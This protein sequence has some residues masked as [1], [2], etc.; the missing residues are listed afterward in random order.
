VPSTP[1]GSTRPSPTGPLP[2]WPIVLRALRQARGITQAGWGARLGYSDKTVRRWERGE[3]APDAAAEAALL[4]VLQEEGLLRSFTAGPLRGLT[5]TAAELCRLLEEARSDTR[6]PVPLPAVLHVVRDS[7][8]VPAGGSLPA[9]LTRLI[10]RERELAAV[11][12]LLATTRLVT[13]TGPPG[14]G[15][16]R[17]VLAVAHGLL[18]AFSDGVWF[19]DLSAVTEPGVVPA[20]IAQVLGLQQVA[21]VPL[22]DALVA[23]LRPRHL[24]LV[25]DNVEQLLSATS[26]LAMLLAAAARL[27]LLVTSREALHLPGEHVY[28]LASLPVP[29][30]TSAASPAALAD[31]PA[32]A[33]FCERARAVQP[34]F[35]LTAQ[36]ATAVAAIC[37]RLDGLPLALELAA[38]RTTLLS[39]PQLLARLAQRLPL[40]TGRGS[41]RPARQHTLRAA[42][43][44]SYDL[45]TADEQRLFRRLAVFTGTFSLATAEAVCAA[46]AMPAVLLDTHHALVEKSLLRVQ[47]GRDG[48]PRL[49]LL[50]TVREF[51]WDQL[52]A[53]GEAPAMRAALAQALLAM[54][55]A[56]AVHCTGPLR[57]QALARLSADAENLRAALAWAVEV[58]AAA[59]GLRLVGALGYWFRYQAVREGLVWVERLLA[60]PAAAE[61]P[62]ARGWALC[63]AGIAAYCLAEYP[64]AVAR[65]D[66]ALRL[67]DADADRRQVVVATRELAMAASMAGRREQA[68]QRAREAV[69]LARE[70]GESWLL[71][72]SLIPLI[73]ATMPEHPTGISPFM[74]EAVQQARRAG[75]PWLLLNMLSLLERGHLRFGEVAVAD[76][77][78]RERAAVQA[79]SGL[80]CDLPVNEAVI[81]LLR[82]GRGDVRGAGVTLRAALHFSQDAALPNGTSLNLA[83]AALLALASGKERQAVVLHSAAV[84]AA[85]GHASAEQLLVDGFITDRT[86]DLVALEA[87]FGAAAY[88]ALWA[89]G[90]SLGVDAAV[91]L[92]DD[93]TAEA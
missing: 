36:N 7:G 85:A 24:L 68:H 82:L 13:V 53:S 28:P 69:A 92:V 80:A 71:A 43:Q 89:E 62:R 41:G 86:R 30:L 4:A 56:E 45:L 21:D 2:P 5:L 12:A 6:S 60:L 42:L 59:L 72:F 15:K 38:A 78:A 83:G 9:P 46:P 35:V 50:A 23:Y 88:A 73:A 76:A 90:Q 63:T 32:V 16:T 70:L 65:F 55:E 44:W 37:V 61:A 39:P 48:E 26:L 67:L 54:A 64:A 27:H 93:L 25:L 66:E 84:A 75:E 1:R 33:L 18:P 10:G 40:L 51:A 87:A 29:D 49:S 52:V 74:P 22:I 31:N 8:A 57:Q 47:S 11:P 91:V 14:C 19:V 20:A 3:T 81:S 79:A 58:G 34:G 17:L 77:I